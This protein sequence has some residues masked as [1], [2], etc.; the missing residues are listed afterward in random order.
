MRSA[1]LQNSFC[2]STMSL[3]RVVAMHGW[4]CCSIAVSLLLAVPESSLAQSPT[5]P[6]DGLALLQAGKPDE[7]RAV[8]EAILGSNPGDPQALDG[9]V[10]ASEALALKE[11]SA[12]HMVEALRDMMGAEDYAPGNARLLFDIGI[13]EEEMQLYP[14]AEKALARAQEI[15]PGNPDNYYAMARVKIDE[16]QLDAA[17]QN[18]TTYLKARPDDASAHY[19]LGRVY[20]LGMQFDQARGE[21]QRSIELQPLQTE[22][23]YE[24]GDVALKQ[25]N[26]SEALSYFEKVLARNGQHGG[27]LTGA[28]QALYREKRY[29]QALAYL[30]RATGAAPGYQPG[31]Y[32]L[33][34]TL[35]RL[36]QKE[37]SDREL[38]TAQKLADE[39]NKNAGRRYQLSGVPPSQ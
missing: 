4:G 31:H 35:S 29:E 33:G 24:L 15:D 7:A 2:P 12:G 9:E 5:S 25:D 14:D 8:F 30:R 6:Q 10:K 36:G 11:R 27:A 32:Y 28:G 38:L 22:A 17:E 13:L 34:L 26:Y 20:E 23:Y 3:V 16:G 37:E 1:E 39:D 21:F 19:G 18:M